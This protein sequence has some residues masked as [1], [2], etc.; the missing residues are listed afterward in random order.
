MEYPMKRY[1]AYMS[2]PEGM[3]PW[4]A[5]FDDIEAAIKFFWREV[6]C[7]LYGCKIVDNETGKVIYK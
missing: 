6:S 5:E 4:L 7:S 3:N 2:K 1:T